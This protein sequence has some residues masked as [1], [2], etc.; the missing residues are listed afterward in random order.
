MLLGGCALW[1]FY[2][3]LHKV[4]AKGMG[5]GDVRL[6]GLVGGYLAWF[7]WDVLVVG[8]FLAFL[9]G[10][11]FGA[12]LMLARGASLKTHIPYGPY[13]IVGSVLGLAFG[14]DLAS[15]YLRASGLT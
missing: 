13:M 6:A 10:G 3:V 4:Y 7:G 15:A 12:L 1:L 2:R 5:Y 9:V 14:H 11:V 8:A